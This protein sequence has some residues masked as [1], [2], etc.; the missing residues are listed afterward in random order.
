M[1]ICCM[2]DDTDF[3]QKITLHWVEDRECQE[4]PT[5]KPDFSL[6]F[7]SRHFQ[8]RKLEMEMKFLL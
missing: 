3:L 7:Q 6:D 5:E 8:E 4:Q 1:L 2:L